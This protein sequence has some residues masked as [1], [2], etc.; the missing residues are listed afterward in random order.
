MLKWPLRAAKAIQKLFE[1]L[2]P[3][4]I[5]IED[6][7]DE[8]FYQRV[9]LTAVQGKVPIA[10]VVALGG[11]TAVLK[12]AEEHDF[13][14]RAALFI[15]DGDIYWTKGHPAPSIPGIY[16]HDAYCIENLLICEKALIHIIAEELVKTEEVTAL[17]L[18]FQ[19]WR[20]LVI[21]NLGELFAAIATV[22]DIDPTIPT[23]ARGVS[24]L[25]T[26]RREKVFQK[27]DP[28]LVRN[29]RDYFLD[30]ATSKSSADIVNALYQKYYNRIK[31][32]PEPLY[33]ISGKTHLL[34]LIEFILQSLGCRITKQTLRMRL[35]SSID[36]SRYISLATA[37]YNSVK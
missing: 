16:C 22:H 9:L 8:A 13:K 14:T 23:V 12:A 24:N 25:C 29:E 5:Y 7:N 6:T 35:A 32:L 1:P 3:I 10:R 30:H 2:Q 20:Q 31:L 27:L 15:I 11:R 19:N 37:I 21:S 4:D 33:A 34:P 18:D 28:A 17:K 26:P 36:P